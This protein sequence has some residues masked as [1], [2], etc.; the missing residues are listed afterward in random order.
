VYI[1]IAVIICFILDIQ[2]AFLACSLA[3]EK[4]GKRI[5]ASIAMIA[6]T[7]SSSMSVNPFLLI[8]FHLLSLLDIKS[9]ILLE[10]F[11]NFK[12]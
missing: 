9:I 8:P 4:T 7:T 12:Y 10:G 6:I 2:D 11:V 1:I 3:R 5:A